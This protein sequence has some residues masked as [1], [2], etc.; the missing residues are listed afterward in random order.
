MDKNIKSSFLK[1]LSPFAP[2]LCEEL[3][4]NIGNKESIF[5]ES[6]PSYD[7]VKLIDKN[8]TVV[9]Q[10]N[11]KLKGLVS[12]KKDDKEEIIMKKAKDLPGVNKGLKD[13]EVIKTIYISG[14]IRYP[15]NPKETIAMTI[16]IFWLIVNTYVQLICNI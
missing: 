12:A 9:I 6:W 8:T 3:W 15:T 2:H 10:I 13:R 7:S 11:G 4:E 16:A 1:L 14:K 5:I